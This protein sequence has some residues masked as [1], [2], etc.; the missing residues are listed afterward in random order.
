MSEVYFLYPKADLVNWLYVLSSSKGVKTC[1]TLS[2]ASAVEHKIDDIKILLP[3]VDF[4][5]GNEEE[6]K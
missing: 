2:A 4:V 3:Y 1:L 6:W 5:F